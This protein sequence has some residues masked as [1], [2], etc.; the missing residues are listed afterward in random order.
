MSEEKNKN[1]LEK[2]KDFFKGAFEDMK[3]NAKALKEALS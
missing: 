3:E 1:I 2:T